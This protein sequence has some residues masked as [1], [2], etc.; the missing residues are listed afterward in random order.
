MSS[1]LLVLVSFFL[2]AVV[3]QQPTTLAIAQQDY[4]SDSKCPTGF[5]NFGDSL[6]D[7]GNALNAFPFFS[8]AELPP[9]GET[10][11]GGPAKR[12]SDGRV[13]PDFFSLAFRKPLLD[14]YFTPTVFNFRHG[15]NFAVAGATAAFSRTAI[16]PFSLTPFQ[17]AQFIRLI[18]S[19]KTQQQKEV[20]ADNLPSGDP[21]PDWLFTIEAG[22]DDLLNGL[23]ALLPPTTMMSSVIPQAV[24][25]ISM[26]IET[27]YAHSARKF[28]VFNIPPQGCST[29][30]LTRMEVLGLPKDKLGCIIPVNDLI[31]AFNTG[32]NQTIQGLRQKLTNATISFFDYYSANMEILENPSSYGFNPDLIFTACCGAP[33]MGSLNYNP[34]VTCGHPGK[35]SNNCANPEE[36]VI[37]DG[38][39]FTESFYRTIAKFA[40]NGEFT[41]E[42]VNYTAVC[43][44]DFSKF[45][46][47][48]TLSEA[49]P[50]GLSDLFD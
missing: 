6:T 20:N 22:G 3:L 46:P 13:V 1:G 38:V 4:P 14:G 33:G 2:G 21:Y 8:D 32:L 7:T 10:F 16:T 41:D 12:F 11:F 17:T 37:W 25:N 48:V 35:G 19:F 43:D 26:A 5:A 50:S 23:Q 45:G 24:G 30:I 40:L 28:L 9:Y 36:Y 44:P 39:H 42:G 31:S 18:N 29:V 34:V 27:L 15:A 49:Y 47:E